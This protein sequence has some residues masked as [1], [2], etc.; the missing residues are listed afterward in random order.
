MWK[1]H[2][3]ELQTINTLKEGTLCL[4]SMYKSLYSSLLLHSIKV[5]S[6]LIES[7]CLSLY[8]ITKPLAVDS[9]GRSKTINEMNVEE[10]SSTAVNVK[11][12][13]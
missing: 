5:T 13:G 12:N 2:H 6:K 9:P 4:Y 8:I 11:L 1:G 3:P 7:I 10:S